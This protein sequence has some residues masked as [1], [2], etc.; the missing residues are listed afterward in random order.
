MLNKIRNTF[1][2]MPEVCRILRQLVLLMKY[3]DKDKLDD[4]LQTIKQFL[5]N[6]K[7]KAITGIV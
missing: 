4:P 2:D 1:T 6:I 7:M 5:D 3:M